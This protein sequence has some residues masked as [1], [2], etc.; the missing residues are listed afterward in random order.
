MASSNTAAAATATTTTTSTTATAKA[1]STAL[2]TTAM[3]KT[4]SA[5]RANTT[6]LTPDVASASAVEIAKVVIHIG[7]GLKATSSSDGYDDDAEDNDAF[8]VFLPDGEEEEEEEEEVNK[9]EITKEIHR[10]RQREYTKK[11]IEK[12]KK[13]LAEAIS[14]GDKPIIAQFEGKK[15][16][17]KA[18]RQKKER[19]T[20]TKKEMIMKPVVVVTKA[21]GTS[22][23]TRSTASNGVTSRNHTIS[24]KKIKE[25]TNERF[26]NDKVHTYLGSLIKNKRYSLEKIINETS[27]TFVWF[28][29]PKH[30]TGEGKDVE[31]DHKKSTEQETTM[32]YRPSANEFHRWFTIKK[33]SLEPRAG[34]TTAGYGLFADRNFAPGT[35]ISMY[36][37]HHINANEGDGVYNLTYPSREPKDR[38]ATQNLT[39]HGGF[40]NCTKMYLGAHMMNN[41]NWCVHDDDRNNDVY[42]VQFGINLDVMVVKN[43]DVGDELF[44][45]YNYGGND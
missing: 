8:I 40:P 16:Q 42:N 11:Y 25:N 17:L 23:T 30:F 3:K 39:V 21:L 37:G 36:L 5:T 38:K 24:R 27:T 22:P 29:M 10:K 6:L 19:K 14:A 7:S 12:Q 43:I 1:T 26:T 2:T 41:P 28:P 35:I 9:E 32:W 18:K 45:N 33:L 34:D 31:V 20:I 4:I 44:V 13:I 15:R